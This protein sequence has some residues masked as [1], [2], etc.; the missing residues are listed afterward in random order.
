MKPYYAD[1]LV[2]IYH[3]DCRE[4]IPQLL[5]ADVVVTDPPYGTGGWRRPSTGAGSDPRA[6]EPVWVLSRDGF[7]LYGGDDLFVAVGPYRRSLTLPESLRRREVASAKVEAGALERHRALRGG[8]VP[9]RDGAL[10]E[11]G[12]IERPAML[13]GE[14]AHVRYRGIDEMVEEADRFREA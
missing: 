6:S 9:D 13:L 4:V 12:E 1:D 14:A 5:E 8:R 10:P 11:G 2:T 7:T 3:G